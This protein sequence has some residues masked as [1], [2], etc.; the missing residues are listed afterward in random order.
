MFFFFFLAAVIARYNRH[1]AMVMQ[2]EAV[3]KLFIVAI[4]V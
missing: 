2:A 1:S 4:V 3:R